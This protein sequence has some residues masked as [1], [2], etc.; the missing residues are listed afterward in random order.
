[1]DEFTLPPG[2]HRMEG[3]LG[4]REAAAWTKVPERSAS[5]QKNRILRVYEPK[6]GNRYI[7]EHWTRWE[8]WTK[9]GAFD[10]P[11]TAMLALEVELAG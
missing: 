1:M 8:G 6:K 11:L 2:W 10:H 5:T 7:A 9:L 3:S 4:R